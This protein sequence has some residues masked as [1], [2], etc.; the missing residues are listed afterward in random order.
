VSQLKKGENYS[1]LQKVYF[2][3]FI[4]FNMF[5]SKGY[6]SRHLILNLETHEQDLDSFNF[7]FIELKKFNKQL[8]EL[9]NV[10]D[11]WV[12]FIKNAK[13]LTVIYGAPFLLERISNSLRNII[14]VFFNH[15]F[16]LNLI[17]L[18]PVTS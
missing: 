6:L 12:Y 13:N 16:I 11:K 7:S 5:E 9:E 15:N 10:L 2:I 14:L 18:F 17:V 4:N 3:A 1:K 8:N